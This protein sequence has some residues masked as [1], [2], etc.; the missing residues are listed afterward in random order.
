MQFEIQSIKNGHTSIH[1]A[2]IHHPVITWESC[3]G[4]GCRKFSGN[5]L[6]IKKKNLW[7]FICLLKRTANNQKRPHYH[8][9]EGESERAETCLTQVN[10]LAS[11]IPRWVL[12]TARKWFWSWWNWTWVSDGDVGNF[13]PAIWNNLLLR[14]SH[15]TEF[16]TK[17]CRKKD[18]FS[19]DYHWSF[20]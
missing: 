5:P 4:D 17:S 13:S 14:F 16:H 8:M 10:S 18:I 20:H 2:G 15:E 6:Y 12:C 11:Y 3:V 1:K 7:Q 19:P 9:R